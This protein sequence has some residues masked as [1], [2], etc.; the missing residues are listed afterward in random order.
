MGFLQA[1]VVGNT[2]EGEPFERMLISSHFGEWRNNGVGY[3]TGIDLAPLSG[4]PGTPLVFTQGAFILWCGVYGGSRAR[5]VN[6]GYGNVLLL[7]LANQYQILVAHLES[8]CPDITRWI[9]SGYAAHLKPTFSPG[10]TIAYQGNTGY[11]YGTLPDGSY[12]IPADDDAISGTH[13]HLEVRNPQ[14]QLVNPISVIT[15]SPQARDS[16]GLLVF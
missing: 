8:F 9:D 1:T 3:H 5:D 4:E 16:N 14:G 2:W 11:V 13:T 7:R 12:G 15:N 6:G 10:E